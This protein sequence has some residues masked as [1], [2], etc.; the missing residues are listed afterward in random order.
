VYL[1]SIVFI[2]VNTILIVKEYYWG[3]I[4][5][6]VLIIFL[7]FIFS[8][9]KVI[10]IITFLTPFAVNVRSFD[11][12][13]GISIPTEPLMLG[14]LLIFFLKLFYENSVE[15]RFLRHPVTLAILINLFWIF[16]TSL[17]SE[18][19]LVSFKFLLARLW[20]IVPFYF[21]IIK[22]FKKF[23]KISL[24]LW[25]YIVPL[26]VV[27]LYTL[28]NHSL[29]GFE[30]E[31]G[32]T[33]MTP[34]YNDHTSYGAV[35]ALFLPFIFVSVFSK[36]NT[37]SQ[38]VLKLTVLVLFVMALV[39]SYSRAAWLSVA[40]AIIIYVI[41]LLKIKFKWIAL[42]TV[43]VVSGFIIFQDEYLRVLKKTQE[44]HQQIS[45]II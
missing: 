27:I 28:Y 32:H 12:G 25:L 43:I 17:T 26:S 39:F 37:K 2:A 29:S 38:R 45:L 13:F 44:S 14:V 20:F 5:P 19:P 7:L 4:I 6:L 33:V 34:F 35:L 8:L 10:F 15:R 16:I 31:A 18:M 22:I 11:M 23:D 9:D 30:E 36:A 1:I 21:I 41:I 42:V 24:F 3:L 40:V